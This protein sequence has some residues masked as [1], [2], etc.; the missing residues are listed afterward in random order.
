MKT[1]YIKPDRWPTTWREPT[2]VAVG[3][4]L[5]EL[6]GYLDDDAPDVAARSRAEALLGDLLRPVAVATI[7]VRMP[8]D[9]RAR[10]VALALFESPADRRTLAEWG[11]LVGAS[12]RTLARAFH[13]G[14]GIP[15]GR[16]RSLLRLQ[17]ALPRLATGGPVSNVA[18]EL[19]YDTA[20]AF[21]A[22]F[23]RETG[24]TPGAYF[25]DPARH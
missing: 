10:Q 15:F 3:P 22:A 12:G 16:W 24:L 25:A 17:A 7:D 9:E 19:G 14:T 13:A 23:R 4:L 1:L 6:I 11:D 21:V 20:S 2:P 8:E 5:V 18:R